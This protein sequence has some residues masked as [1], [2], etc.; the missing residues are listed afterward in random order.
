MPAIQFTDRGAAAAR[1]SE[2]GRA[3]AQAA[4]AAL[5]APSILNTQPWR[6]RIGGDI[7]QLRADRTRQVPS[8]D[9]DGRLLTLSCGIALHHARTAL[10]ALGSDVDVA[11]LPEAADPGLLATL[12]L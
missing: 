6:W 12:R 3:L 7:A 4:V 11:H 9:P 5:G 10:T 8:I 1:V 2:Q